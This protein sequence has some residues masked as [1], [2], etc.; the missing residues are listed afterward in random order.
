MEMSGHGIGTKVNAPR[1]YPFFT[2]V[3]PWGWVLLQKYDL[4]MASVCKR[5]ED[6]DLRIAERELV[7]GC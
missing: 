4:E 1:L 6:I 7:V 2:T 3:K 5:G